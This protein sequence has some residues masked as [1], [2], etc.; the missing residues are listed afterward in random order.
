MAPRYDPPSKRLE[1]YN[2]AQRHGVDAT[3]IYELD[4]FH[5][6]SEIEEKQF[7]SLRIIWKETEAKNFN[8]QHWGLDVTDA[9]W[10][11]Q[12]LPDWVAYTAHVQSGLGNSPSFGRYDLLWAFQ[13]QIDSIQNPRDGPSKIRSPIVLRYRDPLN[14]VR[15]AEPGT[16]TPASRTVP[17]GDIAQVLENL[18][19]TGE[20][21]S[22][23]LPLSPNEVYISPRSPVSAENSDQF[24]PADDEQTVNAALI[25]LL[26]AVCLNSPSLSTA[27]TMERK[28]FVF[29]TRDN[30]DKVY[31]AR[32]DGHLW[33]NHASEDRSL[34][35]LEVKASLRI[36]SEPE[37]QE[38]AQMAAWI[39]SEPDQPT[40]DGTYR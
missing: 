35:I 11:L 24:P 13:K 30:K 20:E 40:Q 2:A 25:L 18:G 17:L 29:R 31:E 36:D 6:G 14:K 37:M 4:V 16:P 7:L 12:N 15:Y 22:P 33:F 10:Q 19:I 32:T 3:S 23:D 5:P 38:S 1:W 39:R 27:W 28:A 26:K 8:P 34:A 9:R 21:L